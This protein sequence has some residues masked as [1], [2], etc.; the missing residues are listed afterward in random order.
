[1][2]RQIRW[3]M[4]ETSIH[5]VRSRRA[6]SVHRVM[7]IHV[8]ENVVTATACSTVK[9]KW[10]YGNG[11]SVARRR[12]K[13]SWVWICKTCFRGTLCTDI[14]L[15]VPVPLSCVVLYDFKERVPCNMSFFGKPQRYQVIIFRLRFVQF[16]L[17][18]RL[19]LIARHPTGLSE[20][21]VRLSY[22]WY[23]GQWPLML[24]FAEKYM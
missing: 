22:C 7:F 19:H 14:C 20:S 8:V 15:S 6:L 16:N 23:I 24:D 5:Q 11:K 4:W 18:A 3:E 1:M 10:A 17:K 9:D 21:R 13:L 12:P 2:L